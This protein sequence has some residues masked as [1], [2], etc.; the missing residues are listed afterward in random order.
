MRR[1]SQ[2]GPAQQLASLEG[3]AAWDSR[4][5]GCWDL[6]EQTNLDPFLQEAP[7][8]FPLQAVPSGTGGATKA[9]GEIRSEEK[10]LEGQGSQSGWVAL[11]PGISQEL[12]A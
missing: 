10:A 3:R 1:G 11:L 7:P 8:E 6:R 9:A 4:G 2:Q 5:L 12:A